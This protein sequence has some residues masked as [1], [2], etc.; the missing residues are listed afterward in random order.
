MTMPSDEIKPGKELFKLFKDL[1]GYL[2]IQLDIFKLEFIEKFVEF[3]S[4]FYSF[5]ILLVIFALIFLF[6]SLGAAFY[7]GD[8]FKSLPLGFIS[9]G[10]FYII[11]AFLFLILRKRLITRPL[12]RFFSKIFFQNKKD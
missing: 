3:F 5:F 6:I 4:T 9:I 12:I 7:I 1:K 8:V 11:M 10:V 2:E